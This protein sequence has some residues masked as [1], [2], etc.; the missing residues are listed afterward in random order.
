MTPV[1][2]FDDDEAEVERNPDREG[3]AEARGRMDVRMA[4]IGPSWS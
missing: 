3:F 4:V 2:R 1:E